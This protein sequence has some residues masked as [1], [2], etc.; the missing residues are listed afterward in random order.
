MSRRSEISSQDNVKNVSDQQSLS[1]MKIP[2]NIVP[3]THMWLLKTQ[4]FARTT[5]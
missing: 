3:T 5:E 4:N 1:R 2:S